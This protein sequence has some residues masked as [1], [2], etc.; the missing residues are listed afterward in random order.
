MR[1]KDDTKLVPT[2]RTHQY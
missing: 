1:Q 2:L